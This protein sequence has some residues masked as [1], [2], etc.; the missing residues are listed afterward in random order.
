MKNQKIYD[1]CG[2]C[3]YCKKPLKYLME[4]SDG[5][6]K[7]CLREYYPDMAEKIIKGIEENEK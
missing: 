4:G 6:C 1:P 5:M 2:K 3:A 7:D